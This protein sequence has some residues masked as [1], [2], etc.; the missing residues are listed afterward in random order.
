ML[1]QSELSEDPKDLI[2]NYLIKTA[3]EFSVST[4]LFGIIYLLSHGF[5]K[6]FLVVSLWRGKLWA[7]PTAIIVFIAFGV[8]QLYRFYFTHSLW[9]IFL[10]V[11]DILVIVLT[12]IEYKQLKN[13]FLFREVKGQVNSLPPRTR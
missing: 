12:G 11:L 8:Y 5:I 10:T 9:L 13:A 7:Y 4:Q 2:A 1:T 6:I 3:Q